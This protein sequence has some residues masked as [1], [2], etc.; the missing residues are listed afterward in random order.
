MW[1]HADDV[2]AYPLFIPAFVIVFWLSAF[3]GFYIGSRLVIEGRLWANRIIYLGILLFTFIWIFAQP[4]RTMRLGTY[5]E[6]KAVTAPWFFESGTFLFMFIL[7]MIIWATGIVFFATRL[8]R[9]GNHLDIGNDN[10]PF[11]KQGK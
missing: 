3:L 7:V 5:T 10:N 4:G 1:W 8:W 6:W 2:T 11:G 9:M